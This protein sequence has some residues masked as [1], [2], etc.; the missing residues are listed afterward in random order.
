MQKT[1]KCQLSKH[2]G[3]SIVL[4]RM[5]EIPDELYSSVLTNRIY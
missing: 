3:A 1:E 2:L 5:T 4:N